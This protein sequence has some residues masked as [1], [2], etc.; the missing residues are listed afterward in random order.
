[1]S[2]PVNSRRRFFQIGAVIGASSVLAGVAGGQNSDQQPTA[3][4]SIDLEKWNQIK[5][6]P[7]RGNMP[8]VSDLPGPDNKRNW[9]DRDKY[10][11]VE[12]I[13][14]MCQLCSSVCGIIGYVKEGRLIKVEGNPNDPNSRGY[15]CARGQAA[16]NHQYHPERLLFPLK[17][18]GKR[19]EGKWKRITW[20]EALDEIAAKLKAVRDSGR[21]EEFAFHQGRLRSK[22]AVQ[23]FLAAFGTSTQLNHRALCSG[24]R[25][26]ANLTYLWESDWDLN[27]VEHTKYILNFGSNA[28]EAH[29]GHIPFA[30]RIQKGRFE[31]GAKLVTFDVRMS[32]TAGASDEWFAPFPGTDGAIALAIGH[33]IL[34]EN[35]HDSN[36]IENWTNVSVDE[37]RE[38]LKDKTPEWAAKISG[39]AA[40]DIRRIAIEFA[41][42]APAATTMCNRGSSAHLNGFYNDRAIGLLNAL[43]G[44]VGKKGGWCWSP[45]SGIDPLVKTPDMPSSPKTHSVLED[46]PEYPLANVWRRMRVG[47]II[48]LYLLQGRAKMQAYMTYNLDSPLTWP[49]E[50]LT[51]QVMCDENLIPFHVCIN[52]FYNETAHYADIVLPWSTYLERWDLDARGSYNLRPYVGLRTPMV[53]PLGES[54]DVRDFFPDLARRIG[55]G[56]EET[57]VEK[58]VRQYM[59]KW[60]QN[61]PENPETGKS[62]LDRLLDEGVW[63][64]DLEPFYEPYNI[65]LTPEELA[66]SQTND[67]GIITKEGVGIGI[68]LSDRAVRGFKTPSRKF[69]I[70]SAFVNRIAKNQD[71]SD[72]IALSGMTKTSNRPASH[73]GHDSEVDEMPIWF[74]PVEM[75]NLADDELVM[76]SFKWNVHN[77]GRTMNLKWLAEIVHSNPAWLNPKTAERLGVVDG[78]WIEITS[79]HS[80]HLQNTAPHLRRDEWKDEVGR[81]EVSKMRVPIVTMQGI[82]PSAIAM[83]NSCGHTQYTSVAQAKKTNTTPGALVGSDTETYHDDDWQRNMWWQD[84]S[85]GDES[86]WKKNTGNGWNQNKLLP[87]SP[88]P[89]S[90]QQ[91]FH[92]TIVSVKKV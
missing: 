82:H 63:E 3:K 90:G 36:F 23:R 41:N 6:K 69:E 26:A 31:N 30:S 62:G 39:V 40:T 77:H 46:P 86:K 60:S 74:Q 88:D 18:I 12:K 4:P 75:T 24:N 85:G 34:A 25:R 38:F 66:G 52:A 13:P 7:Y 55:G 56:M 65:A 54:R 51:Q 33:T 28:F 50:S 72:L 84:E 8:G 48:Y 29:Q 92:D 11:N 21:P 15:L 5:G 16:L 68:W 91:S 61:I 2:N 57:Y 32:N 47:E 42:A 78:D 14:G 79:Y 9:P 22:D 43:V 35:L 49:E 64:S 1:M 83:S 45:W 58:D 44:S 59:E 81:Q 19:G 76:T 89:I 73:E 71:C 67:D 53:K 20:D 87:I 37:L 10:K 17:R 80:V 27:D 70:R